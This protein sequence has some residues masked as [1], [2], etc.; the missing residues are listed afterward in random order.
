MYNNIMISVQVYIAEICSIK[1]RGIFGSLVPLGGTIGI[2]CIS[3]FSYYYLSLVAIGVVAVFEV[4]MVWLPDTPKWLLSRGRG[5]EAERVLLW[6]RGKEIS[7]QQELEEMKKAVSANEAQRIN[8]QKEF[9]K[10]S[11]LV[12]F[13]YVLVLLIFQ[14]AGGINAIVPFAATLLSNAG[15]S[16]P[17]TTATI[18]IGVIGIFGLLLFIAT[19]NLIGRTALLVISGAGMFLSCSMLGIHFFITRPSLCTNNSMT[20]PDIDDSLCNTQFLMLATV[21]VTLF[22]FTFILGV[23]SVPWILISEMIS[24]NVRGVAS[25][26]CVMTNWGMA[27]LFSG[28]IMSYYSLVGPWWTMWTF[29]AVNLACVLFVLIFITETKGKSLEEMEKKFERR[30]K[31]VKNFFMRCAI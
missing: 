6:L 20:E 30:Q 4:L 27:A 28:T 12:P 2:I 17:R 5:K 9:Q 18:T 8:I 25:G 24:L 10:R 11:V 3:G 7:I 15:V 29:S 19:V 13:V 26:L 14:Q 23:G 16:N 22:I 21:S 31:T 1:L